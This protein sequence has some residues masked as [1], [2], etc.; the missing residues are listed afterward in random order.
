MI[1]QRFLMGSVSDHPKLYKEAYNALKPGG[2]IEIIDMEC[3]LYSDDDS[4]PAGSA[5]VQWGECITEAFSKLGKPFP[6]I[7][8]Y[9]EYLHDQGFVNITSKTM[10]RPTNDWPKD[11]KMKEIG[12]YCCLNFLEGLEGFT[13]APFTRALGWTPDE[14]N[15][16]VAR[17]RV[18]TVKRSIHGWHKG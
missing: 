6:R 15:I 5:L 2:W 4:I 17:L 3:L 14:V 18:E 10:K 11:S 8:K 16:L 12:Q 13:M 7:E 9:S 1:H